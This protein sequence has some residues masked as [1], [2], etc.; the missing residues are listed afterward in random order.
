MRWEMMESPM[1]TTS[2]AVTGEPSLN[3]AAGLILKVH[4]EPSAFGVH[5][6]ASWPTSVRSG[7]D[8]VRN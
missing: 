2:A 3:V 7:L 1:T 8:T 5:S 6:V 4:S